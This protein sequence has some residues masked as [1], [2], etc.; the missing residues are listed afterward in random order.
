M[1]LL[2]EPSGEMKTVVARNKERS[3]IPAEELQVSKS[4]VKRGPPRGAN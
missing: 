1:L 2:A 4:V 3:T